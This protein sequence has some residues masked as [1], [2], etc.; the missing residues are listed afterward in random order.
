MRKIYYYLNFQTT[1]FLNKVN[2]GQHKGETP[3][4]QQQVRSHDVKSDKPIR[5]STSGGSRKVSKSDTLP[6][7]RDLAIN[8]RTRS[9]SPIGPN[10]SSPLTDASSTPFIEAAN[11][12]FKT[13]KLSATYE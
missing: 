7:E 6:K 9:R 11:V 1:I 8:P 4:K 2:D 13:L 10:N 5:R 12:S 3:Q